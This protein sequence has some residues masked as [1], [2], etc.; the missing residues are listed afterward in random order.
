MK[1]KIIFSD[2]DGTFCEKDIGHHLYTRFSGGKNKKYVE[3][4]KKGLISTKETLIRETSLLNVDEKQIYQF[5]DRFRL[6]KGARELYTF[7]KSSQIPFYIVS[8]GS[9]IYVKYILKKYRLE[10]IRYF[11][12]RVKIE[13]N[14]YLIEFPYDNGTCTR[15]GCCKGARIDEIVGGNRDK[16]EVIFVGDGLSDI[17]A[18]EQ[19]DRIFARGDLLEYCRSNNINA[20]AYENFFDILNWLKNQV[21]HK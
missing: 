7:A 20:C 21:N 1:N 9:D 6:R 12:N 2:F 5:L 8:D 19:A 13:D 15:C 16:W 4:W 18:L 11:T 14:R 17:C 10:E 3:M